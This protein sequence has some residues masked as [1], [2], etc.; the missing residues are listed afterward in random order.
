[1]Q[2]LLSDRRVNPVVRDGFGLV[3]PSALVDPMDH[4]LIESL[5][6]GGFD[7]FD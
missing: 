1:M 4:E 5:Y 3:R 7:I 2:L 6:D